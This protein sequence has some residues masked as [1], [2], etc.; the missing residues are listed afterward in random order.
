MLALMFEHI[1]KEALGGGT[2]DPLAPPKSTT[3]FIT[4]SIL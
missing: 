4:L 2:T 1:Y 3:G